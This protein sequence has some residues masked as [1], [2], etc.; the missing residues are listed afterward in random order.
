MRCV[1]DTN[2]LELK[3]PYL[4]FRILFIGNFDIGFSLPG[5]R[6]P[7]EDQNRFGMQLAEL[8]APCLWSN[9]VAKFILRRFVGRYAPCVWQKDFWTSIIARSRAGTRFGQIYPTLPLNTYQTT[10]AVL[11][12]PWEW[13][14][15]STGEWHPYFISSYY[16]VITKCCCAFAILR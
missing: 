15:F 11:R 9:C 14:S 7:G 5:E 4:T 13:A 12:R 16:V 10:I 1:E 2:T 6:P 3:I 8:D